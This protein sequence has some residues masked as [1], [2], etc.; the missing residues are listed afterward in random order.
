MI[1][2][3]AV[4]SGLVLEGNGVL[5]LEY[6]AFATGEDLVVDVAFGA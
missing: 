4:E 1:L 3:E 2:V 6:G 5:D